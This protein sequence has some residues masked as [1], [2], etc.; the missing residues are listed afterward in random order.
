MEVTEFF[1]WQKAYIVDIKEIDDQHKQLVLILNKLYSAFMKKEHGNIITEVMD[2]LISYTKYHFEA[3]E[4]YFVLFG[5]KWTHEHIRHHRIFIDKM[6][7]F[8]LE[9]AN[10]NSATTFKLINFLRD[11]LKNHI[12][13]EDQKYVE[14][15]KK[16]GLK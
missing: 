9:V 6:K 11:W 1:P 8:K 2:E 14:L 7:A 10:K 15:F 12:T 4:K 5:Y 13:V 16:E 3:E